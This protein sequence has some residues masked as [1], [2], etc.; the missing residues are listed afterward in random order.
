MKAIIKAA[1]KESKRSD[2]RL[3]KNIVKVGVSDWGINIYEFE[4]K[5]KPGRFRGVM[6]QE[7]VDT[8]PAALS[9]GQDGYYRVDYS[10]LD[11]P[12]EKVLSV[13]EAHL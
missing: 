9:V 1:P 4:Y 5:S 12:F 13:S 10:V 3:K 8:Y 6:A 2:I 7:L 11:V